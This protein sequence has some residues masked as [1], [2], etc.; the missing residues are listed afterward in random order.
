MDELLQHSAIAVAGRRPPGM[1]DLIPGQSRQGIGGSRPGLGRPD[2]GRPGRTARLGLAASRRAVTGVRI[3]AAL[4]AEAWCP[5]AARLPVPS[6]CLSAGRL[7]ADRGSALPGPVAAARDGLRTWCGG[8][9]A[10]R[11]AR[12][13]SR[14]LL[15]RARRGLRR[16]GRPGCGRSGCGRSGCGRSGGRSGCAWPR[17]GRALRPQSPLP[18]RP[19]WAGPPGGPGQ[20]AHRG[21]VNRTWFR[22][23]M[24]GR[25]RACCGGA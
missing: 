18:V 6:R 11:S 8:A 9:I 3:A 17:R 1:G 2:L 20:R 15:C 24:I 16:R 25:A 7:L 4:A 22:W 5:R 14:G 21:P 12:Q 23:T 10:R 13:G 19:G